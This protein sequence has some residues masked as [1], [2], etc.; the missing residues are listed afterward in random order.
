MTRSFDEPQQQIDLLLS[1]MNVAGDAIVVYR[2][3]GDGT[4]SLAYANF[5]YY[6]Q[7]GYERAEA[8][9]KPLEWF[10]RGMPDDTGMKE[11]RAAIAAGRAV[12]TELCSYRQDGRSYWN[13]VTLQPI[14]DSQGTIAHWISVERDVTDAVER[15]SH[16]ED[17]NARL[18][19]LG[20]A[21]RNLFGVLDPG[22]LSERFQIAV[23]E[24]TGAAVS[25]HA[26]D[27]E[28]PHDELIARALESGTFAADERS[29][30]LVLPAG[31]AHVAD[32][33]SR[34]PLREAD[35]V[36]IE[37]LAQYYAIAQHNASLVNEIEEQRNAVLELNQVKTDLIA[38]LAH[39]FKGPLTNILGYADLTAEMGD[40][41]DDQREYLDS[42]RRSAL[43]LAD[44]ATDTLALSRLE[45]NEIELANEDVNVVEVLREVT[46][47][48]DLRRIE[49][50]APD[51]LIVHGDARRLRQVFYNLIENAVKYS[52]G[53]QPVTVRALREN[54]TASIEIVDR[55]IGIPK[56][57][58]PRVFDRFSRAS[59]ARKMRISG[60]GFGLFLAHQIAEMHGGR[61]DVQSIEGKGSTFRIF[62]PL[63]GHERVARRLRVAVLERRAEARSFITHAL[64]E[65]G[66]RTRLLHS[67]EA[68]LDSAMFETDR[69]VIDLDAVP[70][71]G[72]ER[73]SIERFA[74]RHDAAL[75]VVGSDPPPFEDGVHVLRKPYLMRDLIAAVQGGATTRAGAE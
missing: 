52:P 7:T 46:S 22:A 54:D 68:L 33:R 66:L 48:N 43:R 11:V 27:G 74:A 12:K 24:L 55:G 8:I 29:K 61:I 23:L 4:L 39:D 21:A 34:R 6:Q 50:Y 53:G 37:L 15:E 2:A 56:A 44:L 17:Q 70:L 9:G 63:A 1:A 69:I 18:V 5:A 42:I 47:A 13:Q 10:R 49:F 51:D 65:A 19:A 73:T 30:R 75:I 3:G 57:D 20:R 58:L 41:N 62:L 64:R 28:A 16:L 25:V 59:N 38:M 72:E 71:S 67:V 40:L 45:R 35:I 36:V 26:I 60:T 14:R 32:V 31:P